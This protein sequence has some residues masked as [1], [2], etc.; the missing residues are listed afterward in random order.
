MRFEDRRPDKHVILLRSSDIMQFACCLS[1]PER[2]RLRTF[3]LMQ[4]RY[5]MD[6]STF[7]VWFVNWKNNLNLCWSLFD[8]RD[9]LKNQKNVF[10]RNEIISRKKLLFYLF[11]HRF[12]YGQ[13][14]VFNTD[15]L[16]SILWFFCQNLTNR[17]ISQ[18]SQNSHQLFR[19]RKT[20]DV[21]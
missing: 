4:W 5:W 7:P 11:S 1:I 9:L 10:W 6:L 2:I 12:I 14:R 19:C 13:R 8:H 16:S 21:D 18:S 20:Y 3:L 15:L 17:I